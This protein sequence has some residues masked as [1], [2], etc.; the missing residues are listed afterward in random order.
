MNHALFSGSTGRYIANSF[1][2]VRN[3]SYSRMEIGKIAISTVVAILLIY[4]S[5]LAVG[6]LFDSTMPAKP[7]ADFEFQHSNNS[8]GTYQVQAIFRGDRKITEENTERLELVAEG[9]DSAQFPL[10]VN[11]GD[12][13]SIDGVETETQVSIVWKGSD[14]RTATLARENIP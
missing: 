8:N 9:G 3:Y 11:P 4:G 7:E 13:V 14:G 6:P 2:T 1:L 10:P 5:Y 12:S